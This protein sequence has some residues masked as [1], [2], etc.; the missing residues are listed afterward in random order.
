M[1]CKLLRFNVAWKDYFILFFKGSQLM[2]RIFAFLVTEVGQ[3]V[4]KPCLALYTK[5]D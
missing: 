4:P 2:Y 3:Q 1:L 5:L